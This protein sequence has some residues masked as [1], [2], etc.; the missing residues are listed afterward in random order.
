MKIKENELTLPLIQGGMGIGVS[1]GNLAGHVAQC[2]GMGVI[3]AANPGYRELDF[4]RDAASANIRALKAEIAKAKRIAGGKGLV[5]MNIMVAGNRYA[6][7]IKVAIE[8]KIDCIISGAGL[9][10]ELP[11]LAKDSGVAL[12]PIVSSGKAAKVI[13]SLWDK[14]HACI[15]DFIVLEGPQAGG[16]LGFS[17]EELTSG[18]SKSLS[19]LIG[20]VL[21]QLI[22]F[23]EKYGRK[24]PLFAAGGLHTAGDIKACIDAGASGVQVATRFIATEECDASQGYKDIL[25]HA[26]PEDI[27]IVKSPVGMPGRA[28]RTPLIERIA[29]LGRVAPKQ[30]TNCL[31]TCDPATTPYCITKALIEA[32]KGNYAQGLFFCGAKAGQ[33]DK[34]TT[35]RELIA[36]LLPEFA[37]TIR[38]NV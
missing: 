8:S 4:W 3:S 38:G 12:S 9:P 10:S 15:P 24:I 14:R 33:V 29:E 20:E 28:L 21:S 11:A 16:H 30:C 19:H 17:S 5:G 13:C 1:L 31:A 2:G 25:L 32:V 7:L 18:T 37:A 26:K 27:L 36:E 35:V 6:E 23:E 34:I 22:P